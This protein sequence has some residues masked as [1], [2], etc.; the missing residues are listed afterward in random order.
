M[1]QP[2]AADSTSTN[3][4][5]NGTAHLHAAPFYSVNGPYCLAYTMAAGLLIV[6]PGP[7][8]LMVVAYGLRLGR[9]AVC[10]STLGVVL[11]D[12]TSLSLCLGGIGGLLAVSPVAYNGLRAVGVLYLLYLARLT[13]R[14]A[15]S[16]SLTASPQRTSTLATAEEGEGDK[17][18]A[19]AAAEREADTAPLD[20][21]ARRPSAHA[22][23][24]SS[25]VSIARVVRDTYFV[26]ATNPK[27]WILSLIHI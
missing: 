12:A 20:A 25:D 26:T 17:V 18:E 27:G 7:T 3:L 21:S 10:A 2:T 1:I 4:S 23:P 11:G 8:V 22:H 13:W 5:A 16:L 19:A 15:H 6:S 24:M 9:R 14:E